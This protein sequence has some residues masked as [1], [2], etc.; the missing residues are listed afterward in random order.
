MDSSF[1]HA[2]SEYPDQT[3]VM[4]RLI[5]I[6]TFYITSFDSSSRGSYD[7]FLCDIAIRIK[8]LLWK[9][10]FSSVV[11]KIKLAI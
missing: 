11:H 4:S 5:R 10:C 2:N 9:A 8:K 7:I 6:F 3:E 1:L